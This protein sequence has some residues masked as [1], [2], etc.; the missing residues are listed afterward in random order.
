MIANSTNFDDDQEDEYED[1]LTSELKSLIANMKGVIERNET[2][3]EKEVRLGKTRALYQECAAEVER[4]SAELQSTSL[5]DEEM[6]AKSKEILELN[7]SSLEREYNILE[8]CMKV[9]EPRIKE[10]VSDARQNL[11]STLR[12]TFN[13]YLVSLDDA[14]FESLVL[15]LTVK[16]SEIMDYR[17]LMLGF[18]D[19]MAEKEMEKETLKSLGGL[20]PLLTKRHYWHGFNE[21]FLK[22]FADIYTDPKTFHRLISSMIEKAKADRSEQQSNRRIGWIIIAVVVGVIAYFVFGD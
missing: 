5:T 11:D 22:P 8:E 1:D 13:E 6:D 4:L 3:A 17:D 10:R 16:K 12:D 2:S 14:R 18:F 19:H 7:I 15:A 9:I 21:L 20:R